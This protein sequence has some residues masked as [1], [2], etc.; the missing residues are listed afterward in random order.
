MYHVY[1]LD[2]QGNL[3]SDRWF[4]QYIDADNEYRAICALFPD[5]RCIIVSNDSKLRRHWGA[6]HALP[7]RI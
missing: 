2:N 7:E 5:L 1:V 6:D 3:R 4:T